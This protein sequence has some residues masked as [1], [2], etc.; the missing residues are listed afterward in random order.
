MC[1]FIVMRTLR[2]YTP[3]NFRIC[4]TAVLTVVIV[5]Y[6]TSPV[7]IYLVSESLYRLTTFFQ[8]PQP[9]PLPLVTTKMCLIFDKSS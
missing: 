7:F 2:S 4:P 8:F 1:F 3:K 9:L 6:M 5:L